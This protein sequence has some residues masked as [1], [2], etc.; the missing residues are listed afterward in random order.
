M[1]VVLICCSLLISPEYLSVIEKHENL[2]NSLG[3]FDKKIV[4]SCGNVDAAKD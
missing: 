1:G 3:Y 4:G 2:A